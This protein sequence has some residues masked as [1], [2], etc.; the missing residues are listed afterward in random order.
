MNTITYQSPYNNFP[1]NVKPGRG[2]YTNIL[3]KIQDRFNSALAKHSQVL[4]IRFDVRYPQGMIPADNS[5]LQGFME[6]YI[7]YLQ[8]H[9]YSPIYLWNSEGGHK[10]RGSR[11]HHHVFL[12]L[13]G[14]SIRYMPNL[15]KA[16]ELWNRALGLPLGSNRKLIHRCHPNTEISPRLYQTRGMIHRS[17][18]EARRQAIYWTSYCGKQSQPLPEGMRRFGCSQLL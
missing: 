5:L 10:K 2:C 15:N 17:D 8:R 14:N 4:L 9:N 16:E 18:M 6:N 11:I 13:N 3:D 1:I 7:R 12:I